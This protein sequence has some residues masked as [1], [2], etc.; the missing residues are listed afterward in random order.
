M[1]KRTLLFEQVNWDLPGLVDG[2]GFLNVPLFFIKLWCLLAL[3]W[4]LSGTEKN[5][6]ILRDKILCDKR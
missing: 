5:A 6:Q 2:K 4:P 3:I 1:I